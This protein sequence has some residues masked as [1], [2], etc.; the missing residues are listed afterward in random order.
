MH[1]VRLALLGAGLRN[2]LLKAIAIVA[3]QPSLGAN[4]EEPLLVLCQRKNRGIGEAQSGAVHLKSLVLRQDRIG[5]QQAHHA[6]NRTARYRTHSL[7][8]SAEYPTSRACLGI[9]RGRTGN[10]ARVADVVPDEARAGY[11]RY[12]SGRLAVAT[13]VGVVTESYPGERRVALAPSALSVLNKTGVELLI[14]S[15]AGAAAGFPDAEYADKGVRVL[16]SRAEV[17]GAAQAILQVRTLGANPDCGRAD[18]AAAEAGTSGDRLR[19]TAHGRRSGHRAG[20]PGCHVLR[21]GADASHHAGAEHGCAI[22][23]GHHRRI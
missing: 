18:L 22:F 15:G 5:A 21:H 4:P 9:V 10:R 1:G 14:Q 19:G 8:L 16:P 23:D 7:F 17:F 11:N 20:C 6:R 13:T 2:E 12:R 3:K